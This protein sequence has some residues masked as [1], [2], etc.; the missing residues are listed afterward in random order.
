MTISRFYLH[1][2]NDTSDSPP[3]PSSLAPADGPYGSATE[4]LLKP[5]FSGNV[6]VCVCVH[7]SVF[8][9]LRWPWKLSA[10]D[11]DI[12]G[13]ATQNAPK[14]KSNHP[15]KPMLAKLTFHRCC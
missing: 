3:P 2:E 1:S 10:A 7:R 12:T 11:N 6:C 14:E 9:V 15:A 5:P 13:V 8:Y 4:D